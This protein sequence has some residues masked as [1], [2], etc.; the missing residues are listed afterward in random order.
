MATAESIDTKKLNQ[1]VEKP[2]EVSG[3]LKYRNFR[4]E[5]GQEV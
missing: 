1:T 3:K 2:S 4:I 5:N